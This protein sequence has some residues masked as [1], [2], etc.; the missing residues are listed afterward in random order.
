[1]HSNGHTTT[2]PLK[3]PSK[4][5]LQNIFCSVFGLRPRSGVCCK[6]VYTHVSTQAHTHTHTYRH[7]LLIGS[8]LMST[9]INIPPNG[10]ELG[11]IRTLDTLYM[12]KT[13]TVCTV[14]PLL[15][16]LYIHTV[17]N[18]FF[19]LFLPCLQ[20]EDTGFGQLV[21]QQPVEPVT[22]GMGRYECLLHCVCLCKSIS[23]TLFLDKP[24]QIC[25]GRVSICVCVCLGVQ[26]YCCCA[27]NVFRK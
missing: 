4:H 13:V 26:Y 9:L 14:F 11:L 15:K 12:V 2:F 3:F 5:F 22:T 19:L 25:Q 21:Q 10:L 20:Y 18:V 27:S 17:C 16:I 24:C 6:R 23:Q 8:L 7:T 1:M